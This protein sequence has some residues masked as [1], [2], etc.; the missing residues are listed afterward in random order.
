MNTPI[1][2]Y[3]YI[4][5]SNLC[6]ALLTRWFRSFDGLCIYVCIYTGLMD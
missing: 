3:I 2:I 6:V 4:Y 1:Y 5:N